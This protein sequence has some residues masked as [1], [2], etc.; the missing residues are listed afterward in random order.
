MGKSG[1]YE[2][3]KNSLLVILNSFS[4]TFYT[5][6]F[7]LL[8]IIY[9][10]CFIMFLLNLFLLVEPNKACYNSFS[11]SSDNSDYLSLLPVT[12]SY[13]LISS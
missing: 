3:L 2:F 10:S 5:S 4:R 11:S 13:Y 9:L 12:V 6:Y 7:Y 8:I 1:A